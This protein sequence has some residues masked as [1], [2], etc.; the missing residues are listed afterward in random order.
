VLLN[1]PVALAAGN[2]STTYQRRSTACK[3]NWNRNKR[4]MSLLGLKQTLLTWWK[5]GIHN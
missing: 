1:I 3:K 5:L 4:I 2:V